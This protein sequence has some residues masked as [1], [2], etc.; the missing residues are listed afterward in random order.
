MGQKILETSI[1][2]MGN[3]HGK[4]LGPLRHKLTSK[5]AKFERATIDADLRK[6]RGKQ[7]ILEETVIVLRKRSS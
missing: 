1:F 3:D 5:P 6:K 7:T 4:G 2:A